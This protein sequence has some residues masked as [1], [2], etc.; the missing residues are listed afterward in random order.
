MPTLSLHLKRSIDPSAADVP[1]LEYGWS[2]RGGR[3]TSSSAFRA[4]VIFGTGGKSKIK[5]VRESDNK[6]KFKGRGSTWVIRSGMVCEGPIWSATAEGR[7]YSGWNSLSNG[8]TT[9]GSWWRDAST[10]LHSS[11]TSSVLLRFG[12]DATF[13]S[14]GLCFGLGGVSTSQSFHHS[15]QLSS[16]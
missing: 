11:S 9:S 8:D 3:D 5:A 10:Q 12:A 6:Q 16:Y 1:R 14:P 13:P 2:S 4:R 7:V 15:I